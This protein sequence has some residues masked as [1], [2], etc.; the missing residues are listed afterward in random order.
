M[1]VTQHDH[2]K[3]ALVLH[4]LRGRTET[5][6]NQQLVCVHMAVLLLCITSKSYIA[7]ILR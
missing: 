3:L 7:V 4:Y 1:D 5:K 2:N 6:T